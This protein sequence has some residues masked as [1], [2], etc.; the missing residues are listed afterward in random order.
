VLIEL[1]A[2]NQRAYEASSDN[3]NG[4]NETAT[5]LLENTSTLLGLRMPVV[6]PQ[7]ES[8]AIW[9]HIISHMQNMLSRESLAVSAG[10]FVAIE[11]IFAANEIKGLDRLSD[12][13][14][15]LWLQ[16]NPVQHKETTRKIVD[17]QPALMAYLSC[18]LQLHQLVRG[19]LTPER[20]SAVIDQILLAATGSS[21]TAYAGDI[22]SLT[23]LQTEIL[24]CIKC[25]ETD[26]PESFSLVMRSLSSLV[27]LP[28]ETKLSP[29][30][31]G[32]T[33]VAL[34]KTSMESLE[35]RLTSKSR[36]E[37]VYKNDA[38]Q[39]A[40]HALSRPIALKYAWKLDGKPP[41]PWRKGT[42]VTLQILKATLPATNGVKVQDSSLETIWHEVLE[43]FAAIISTADNDDEAWPVSSGDLDFDIDSAE[44]VFELTV[45]ALGASELS[46]ELRRSFAQIIFEH[47]IIHDPHLEDLPTSYKEPLAAIHTEHIG[48]TNDLPSSPRSRMSYTLLVML[49]DLVTAHD[50]SSERVKLAQAAAP[51]LILRVSLTLKAYISD[52]PL[53]GRMPQPRSQRHELLWILRKLVALDSEPRAIPEAPGVASK[54]KKHLF[55]IIP[56]IREALK[57]AR[58]D[59]EVHRA[60]EEVLEAISGEFGV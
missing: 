42:S 27:T 17:N 34:S 14:W 23:P 38:L 31:K 29:D 52:Q 18:F 48:R 4:W 50:G 54:H 57:V 39:T 16:G 37:D 46:D 8:T 5:L 58:A 36:I 59:A 32:P 55:R 22:D 43:S 44:V 30:R 28:F 45:P 56:F 1:L 19:K 40:L 24:E 26:T 21:P 7:P 12:P 47:S 15:H 51:Y 9:A 49:F 6:L 35:S 11:K 13:A 25:I 20:L 3:P 41:A 53:R 10:V 60:L 2:R 33:F